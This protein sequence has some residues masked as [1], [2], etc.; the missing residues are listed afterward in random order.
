MEIKTRKGK[1][2]RRKVK[3]KTLVLDKT[4]SVEVPN[5]SY[6]LPSAWRCDLH[7]FEYSVFLF[8]ERLFNES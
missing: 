8:R 7:E 1:E 6:F 5:L 4:A 3:L 2:N